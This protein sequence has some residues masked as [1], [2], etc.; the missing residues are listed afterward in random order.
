MT[1]PA[2]TRSIT[3]FIMLTSDVR[4][5]FQRETQGLG[6]RESG[7]YNLAALEVFDQLAFPGDEVETARP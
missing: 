6:H 4:K 7:R 3:I 5:L 1:W 2:F